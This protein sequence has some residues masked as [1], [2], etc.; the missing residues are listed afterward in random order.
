MMMFNINKQVN[1]IINR[2]LDLKLFSISNRRKFK[3]N[4]ID[5]TRN[6]IDVELNSMWQKSIR[7][8]IELNHFEAY[9]RYAKFFWIKEC[10]D[11]VKNI[12]RFKRRWSFI[13]N[14]NDWSKYTKTNDRKQKIIQKIKKINSR[15]KIEKTIDIFTSL[16]RL[17]K[18]A[19]DRSHLSR[20]IL[21]MLILKF[22]DR[23][24]DT[25]EKKIDMFKSVVFSKSSSL[26]LID[27]SKF[28]YFNSIECFSSITKTKI[29]MII[30]QLIFDKISS[31]DDFINKLLK[32]CALIMIKLFT[33]LF[34]ICIQLFYHSKTFKTINTIILK[35][36]KKNDYIILK[37]YRF[38]ILLN[39]INKIM[40]SI[41]SKQIAWLTKTY[42]L[43]FD[44]HM[45]CRK[46][47][48]IESTLKL[49]TKQIHIVWNKN[50]NRIVILLNLDV[51]E[52][53]DTISH[54]RLI[55]DLRKKRISKWII[56]WMI[57]FLQN[58]TTILTMNYKMIVSFLMRTKFFQKSSL[59]FVLYLF[60][61]VDLL[62]MCDKFEI[63][64]KFL[65]YANDVNI[66]IYDKSTNENCRNLKRVHKLCKRWTTRHEFLFVSIKY[67]LIHFIKNSKKFDMTITIKIE[68]STIQS[69][70][71]I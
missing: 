38:I 29:L 35:K 63:N 33:F 26:D 2:V 16:W 71:D 41:M 31:F 56:D 23:T 1:N 37:T 67:E 45:K 40:K 51:I 61:N 39:I 52:T 24:I 17:T 65:K 62:K 32:A 4:R 46:N 13:Q 28:F 22:N 21:K 25:F 42:R 59:F 69:N 8:R 15:Q 30:K 43:L 10:D 44:S 64:T 9:S 58:R 53:F 60:Y 70:I 54:E 48:S 34:E 55:H 6:Q 18:W 36:A 57:K 66:L 50:T 14:L 11:A 12:R 47:R 27:I 3:S 68:S 20:E 5:S 7:I 49:L 19:K